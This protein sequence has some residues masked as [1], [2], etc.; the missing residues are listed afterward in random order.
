MDNIKL[1][2]LTLSI[3]LSFNIYAVDCYG[4]TSFVKMGE[5]VDQE[6]YIIVRI[7]DKG[8]RLGKASDDATNIQ[9]SIAQ[10]ALVTD[11]EV[12]LRFYSVDSCSAVSENRATPNSFQLVK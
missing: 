8:Y 3:F 10:T 9:L 12:K 2:P 7:N 4:I 5:Y 6:S 1:L 11:K